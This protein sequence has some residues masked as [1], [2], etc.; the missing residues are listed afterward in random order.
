MCAYLGIHKATTAQ[1]SPCGNLPELL[2]RI[3]LDVL[4]NVTVGTI[5]S[6]EN[7]ISRISPIVHMINGLVFYN[8][9]ILSPFLLTFGELPRID[10]L[11]FYSGKSN[12]FKS[13]I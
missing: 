9:K 8:E 2:Y 5:C 11:N 3:I 13:N 12:L 4:R 6:V 1:F 10:I 7:V